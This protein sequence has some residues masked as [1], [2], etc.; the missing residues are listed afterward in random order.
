MH[1]SEVNSHQ[2]ELRYLSDLTNN[3]DQ[4][5]G[6]LQTVNKVVQESARKSPIGLLPSTFYQQASPPLMQSQ[7]NNVSLFAQA[8]QFYQIL[9]K[10]RMQS[11]IREQASFETYLRMMDAAERVGMFHRTKTGWVYARDYDL[12]SGQHGEYMHSSGCYLG[13]M[14][15]LGAKVMRSTSSTV[16]ARKQDQLIHRHESLA[17][18]LTETCHAAANHT[19]TGLP[20]E[21]IYFDGEGRL[22]VT[23]HFGAFDLG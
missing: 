6:Y 18:E 7:F 12:K 22:N 3:A 13:A 19:R 23:H 8:D 9:V 11:P 21:R 1:L 15:T 20:V 17:E 4:L 2:L 14:L 16:N 10:S 5:N